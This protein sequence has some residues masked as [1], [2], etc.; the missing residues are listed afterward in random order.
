MI[1]LAATL[2]LLAATPLAAQTFVVP[3]LCADLAVSVRL[4]DA[5]DHRRATFEVRNLGPGA[6]APGRGAGV[7]RAAL[8][9]QLLPDETSTF[10]LGA[11]AP[12]Q[13]ATFALT[14]AGHDGVT[15]WALIESGADCNGANNTAVQTLN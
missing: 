1:R 5:R 14:R 7:L 4:A 10:A 8:T 12:G 9:S 2:A 13:A 3:G 15:A 6:L 11:L